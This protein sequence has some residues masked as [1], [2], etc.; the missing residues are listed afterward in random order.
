MKNIEKLGKESNRDYAFRVI[1]ENIVNLELEPGSLIS[2]QEIAE[3]LQLSRTPVHEAMQELSSTG[4]LKILPQRGS[5]VTLIDMNLV[6]EAVFV[7]STLESSVVELACKNATEQDINVLEENVNLQEFYY[8]KQNVEK[9]MELDDAF[10]KELY[11]I[12]NKTL[13]YSV[14]RRMNIHHDRVRELHLLSER[15]PIIVKEHKEIL[16]A[17]KEKNGEKAKS[18]I[19]GHINRIYSDENEIRSKYSHY[20]A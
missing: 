11:K 9:L 1:R 16:E 5:L 13:C 15:L 17:I 8:S 18:L 4:I 10:H 6:N 3:E 7:R 19:F 12:A 2:E 20:F 14:V